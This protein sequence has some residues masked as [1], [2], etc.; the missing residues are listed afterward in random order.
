MLPPKCDFNNRI[1]TKSTKNSRYWISSA[2]GIGEEILK[3]INDTINAPYILACQCIDYNSFVLHS[4]Y[5]TRPITSFY[6]QLACYSRCD[7][8][9]QFQITVH[10]LH[11][12]RLR[13]I[14]ASRRGVSI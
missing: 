12:S 14:I 4:S 8:E 9:Y 1:H 11:V 6:L 10:V 2:P 7:F 5:S 13:T 3:P